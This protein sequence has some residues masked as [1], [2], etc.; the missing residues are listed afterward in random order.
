MMVFVMVA[1]S[2]AMVA[3]A[4]PVEVQIYLDDLPIGLMA[5][6]AFSYEGK[7]YVIGGAL[8][9][10]SAGSDVVPSVYIYDPVEGSF[11]RGANM[12][13]GTFLSAYAKGHD[14][15]FYIF[16]GFNQ[17]AGG[18]INKVQIY[19]PANDSWTFGANAPILIG[20]ATAVTYT[21]GTIFVY[22]GGS[23]GN[24][25]RLY[26]YDPV[27]DKWFTM[28]TCPNQFYMRAGVLVNDSAIWFCGGRNLV[29]TPITTVD[30]YNPLT[31]T[32]TTAPDLALAS[33]Y[34]GAA[35]GRNGYVYYLGGFDGAGWFGTENSL[36]NIQLY[37]PETGAWEISSWSSIGQARAAFGLAVDS[38]GRIFI[39]GGIS[40]ATASPYISM[41]VTYD[42]PLYDI[43][44]ASP[45]DGSIVSGD[46]VLIT[47]ISEGIF[48]PISVEIWIDG[49]RVT[50][51]LSAWPLISY[52]YDWDTT[53]LSDKSLHTII[54]R[55]QYRDTTILTDQVSVIFWATSPEEK[56]IDL[57]DSIDDLSGLTENLAD[58]INETNSSMNQRLDAIE[59]QLD[60]LKEDAQEVNNAASSAN[61]MAMLAMILALIAVILIALNLVMSMRKKS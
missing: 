21:N 58:S 6:A 9:D 36:S 47:V 56:I 41:I 5:P 28:Q 24:Q 59:D 19:N 15:R 27:T 25:G 23:T 33:I 48:N 50:E 61:T 8:S 17:S 7:I 13:T 39:V 38:E 55:A 30:E 42:V 52:S 40:Y 46:T 31:D 18:Y 45:A 12:P 22:N 4:E 10:Y 26:L 37:N 16:G 1:S 32:W 11:D 49:V 57:Q 2:I 54:A 44:I 53:G 60:D 14:D 51:I 29:N 3:S 20:R 35:I 43:M 34:G